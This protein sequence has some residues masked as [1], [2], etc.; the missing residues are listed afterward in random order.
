M[1]PVQQGGV[2]TPATITAGVLCGTGCALYV[3]L[4]EP[5]LL[6]PELNDFASLLP[7]LLPLCVEVAGRDSQ[8]SSLVQVERDLTGAEQRNSGR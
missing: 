5:A 4:P 3:R 8:V 7:L 6:L 2:D 1:A